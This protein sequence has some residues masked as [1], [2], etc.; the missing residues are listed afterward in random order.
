MK[1]INPSILATSCRKNEI[2]PSAIIS[3]GVLLARMQAVLFRSRM[4]NNFHLRSLL[5]K[6]EEY[7]RYLQTLEKIKIK[8]SRDEDRAELT[9]RKLRPTFSISLTL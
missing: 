4:R 9:F 6:S 5:K 7:L 2:Q 1:K 3:A 8:Y